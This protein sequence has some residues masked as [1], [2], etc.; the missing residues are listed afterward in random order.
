MTSIKIYEQIVVLLAQKTSW[1]V[2]LRS[3]N[4]D[5]LAIL[6]AICNNDIASHGYNKSSFAKKIEYT[7]K[8]ISKS[9]LECVDVIV[10]EDKFE[11]HCTNIIRQCY[12]QQTS[13]INVIVEYIIKEVPF[14]PSEPLPKG[15][16]ISKSMKLVN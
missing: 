2:K 5:D 16:W 6:V 4:S 7:I 3:S 15:V 13:D 9:N 14:R 8:F 10:M 11:H 12:I 1:E